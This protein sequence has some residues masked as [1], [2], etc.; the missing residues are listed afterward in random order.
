MFHTYYLTRSKII[1]LSEIEVFEICVWL[2]CR[3]L[4]IR[5]VESLRWCLLHINISVL[6]SGFIKSP[7]SLNV[8]LYIVGFTGVTKRETV[9]VENE[10]VPHV[11][12]L[13]QY[14]PSAAKQPKAY[15]V[16]V[17]SLENV[18]RIVGRKICCNEQCSSDRSH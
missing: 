5:G 17:T 11:L 2:S 9:T 3:P 16:G 18:F 13:Q 15:H 12:S 14:W 7:M 6:G 8:Q 10:L 1:N 4:V